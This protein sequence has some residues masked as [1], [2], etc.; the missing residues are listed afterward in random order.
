MS[1]AAVTQSH[2][3]GLTGGV[4]YRQRIAAYCFDHGI[5][6]SRSKARRLGERM[7]RRAQSMQGE[8]DF[9]ESLRILGIHTDSTARDA[10]MNLEAPRSPKE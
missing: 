4:G 8:F 6:I 9:Y 5:E 2:P 7:Y 3:V 10:I 1:T